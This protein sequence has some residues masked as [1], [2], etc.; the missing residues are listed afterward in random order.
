MPATNRDAVANR[1]E[2]DI[3]KQ[4]AKR[5]TISQRVRRA[6]EQSSPDDA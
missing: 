2:E 6:Q 4:D 1:P 3:P 5:A